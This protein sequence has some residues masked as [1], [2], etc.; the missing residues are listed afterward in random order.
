[1]LSSLEETAVLCPSFPG[2]RCKCPFA[3][4]IHEVV[5]LAP[6]EFLMHGNSNAM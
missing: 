5:I 3:Y 4:S 1:M 2:T 6:F